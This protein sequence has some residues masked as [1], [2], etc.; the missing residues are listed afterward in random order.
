MFAENKKFCELHHLNQKMA[1]AGEIFK[2]SH[3][4]GP[5]LPFQLIKSQKFSKELRFP[6]LENLQQMIS[7]P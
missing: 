7:P 5:I 6:P 3:S 4:V 2:K 1:A